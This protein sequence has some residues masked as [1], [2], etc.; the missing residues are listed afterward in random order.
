MTA[1][2]SIKGDKSNNTLPVEITDITAGT[3]NVTYA[4][5]VIATIAGVAA[6]EVEGIAGMHS[7]GGISEILGKNRNVT[8]GVKVEIGT[9]ETSVDLFVTIEYGAPI[10]KAAR[11]AQENVKKAVETMTGLHVVRVDVHVQGV[12]FEKETKALVK[13]AESAKLASASSKAEKSAQKKNLQKEEKKLKENIV[14]DNKD[15]Q[16]SE[17][18]DFSADDAN[19]KE[20]STPKTNNETEK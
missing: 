16:G 1:K 18:E 9:E 12:S 14:R 3:G 20:D 5:E 6:N 19:L 15:Q 4:N 2:D 7:T 13:G 11:D 8:R 17:K 10:H